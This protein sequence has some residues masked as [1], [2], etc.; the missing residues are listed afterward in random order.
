[1]AAGRHELNTAA[2]MAEDREKEEALAGQP[3][4]LVFIS[5]RACEFAF[6]QVYNI[7]SYAKLTHITQ[8]SRGGSHNMTEKCFIHANHI[9]LG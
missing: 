9:Q 4:G 7:H 2:G 3:L 5:V 1:M 8:P 6:L